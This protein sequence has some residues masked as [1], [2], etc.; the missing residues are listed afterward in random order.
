MGI[1]SEKEK[2][3]YGYLKKQ[4]VYTHLSLLRRRRKIKKKGPGFMINL[5]GGRENG[6]NKV[7]WRISESS[8]SAAGNQIKVVVKINR[9]S[10]IL[11]NMEKSTGLPTGCRIQRLS[12]F[13]L[14]FT[15]QDE[16]RVSLVESSITG[17]EKNLVR[18]DRQRQMYSVPH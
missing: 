10:G 8:N 16:H 12:Q 2:K 1:D 7:L 15:K 3:R 18:K 9:P 13:Y 5:S 11:I 4:R 14:N 6:T 17:G